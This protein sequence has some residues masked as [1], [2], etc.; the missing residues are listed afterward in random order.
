[1]TPTAYLSPKLALAAQSGF[2][3][4]ASGQ[5]H[6]SRNWHLHDCAML[7][8]PQTGGL[9][10]AWQAAPIGESGLQGATRLA[11]S[12]ALLLPA[13]TAHHTRSRTVRQRHGEL[14]LAPEL[15]GGL[16][17]FGVLRI[18]GAL[19]ALLDALIAPAL[20]TRSAE[21][22]VDAIVRQLSH[23][24][25]R[26]LPAAASPPTL[27]ARMVRRFAQAL[28]WDQP[29]PLVEDAARDLGVSTRQL[30][31]ACHQEFGASPIEV[32]RRLLAARARALMAEGQALASVSQQLGFATS[33]H[34]GR[35]L[36]AVPDAA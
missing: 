23:G 3:L 1:M 27:G 12:S 15:L 4:H 13:S 7:L 11:R 22:L 33:G 29:L 8:W 26:W 28:E 21:P 19:Q 9:E 30:Q 32:R 35:L 6:Y 25:S 36:R 2:A 17:N 14:Y 31:R 16:A 24:P 5:P 20:D 10:V 34:L 18:D